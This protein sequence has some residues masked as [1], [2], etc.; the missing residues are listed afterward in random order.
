M[1]SMKGR[2]C[3]VTGASTQHG[4]AGT[5]EYGLYDLSIAGNAEAMIA[6]AHKRFGRID[7]LVNNAGIRAPYNFG[8]YTRAQFDA[9]VGVNIATPFFASQ[10]VVPIMRAQGGGRIIGH[11]MSR[12]LGR[13]KTGAR[14]VSAQVIEQLVEC[15]WSFGVPFTKNSFR[16]R[17]VQC[18]D[19]PGLSASLRIDGPASQQVCRLS[20][21]LLR[22]TTVDPQG[23]ELEQLARKVLVQSFFA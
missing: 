5:I 14:W 20:H 9:V 19:E 16:A 13:D 15:L 10:A 8:D 7:V 1:A 3:V 6:D 17:L 4:M 22:V 11:K 18:R 23:V 21:I 12:Q 2:F